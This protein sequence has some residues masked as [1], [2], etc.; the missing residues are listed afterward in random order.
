MGGEASRV[1]VL[2][3]L[4]ARYFFMERLYRDL[5]KSAIGRFLEGAIDIL[6]PL[7]ATQYSGGFPRVLG[8]QFIEPT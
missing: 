2:D 3:Q 1:G 7:I 4:V 5:A 8:S 6:P